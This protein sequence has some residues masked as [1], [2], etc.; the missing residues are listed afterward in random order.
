MEHFTIAQKER[1]AKMDDERNPEFTFNCT[2]TSILVMIAK[3]EIDARAMAWYTL[4]QNGLDQNGEW[5][6]FDK[7]EKIFAAN[8][9]Q[10][11]KI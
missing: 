3:G 7:A 8:V 11:I 4:A 9:S 1:F 2:D 5:V 6:G 10:N